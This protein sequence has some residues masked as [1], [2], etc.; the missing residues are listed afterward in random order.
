MA[1]LEFSHRAEL[2]RSCPY[3][4]LYKLLLPMTAEHP[5]R[6][7][8]VVLHGLDEYH[9]ETIQAVLETHSLA[10]VVQ[11]PNLEA[12]LIGAVTE[13]ERRCWEHVMRQ[14]EAVADAVASET[15]MPCEACQEMLEGLARKRLLRRV[16]DRF[17][18]LG[19]AA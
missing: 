9:L 18:P 2:D 7:G 14:G 10:L 19:E 13:Q 3:V 6:D 5:P 8:Y 1:F 4:I 11:L 15:G 12:R 17:L 16:A